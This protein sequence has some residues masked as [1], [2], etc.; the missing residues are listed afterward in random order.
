MIVPR[1]Y[2]LQGVDCVED[3]NGRALLADDMGL[4][5]TIQALLCL[6][7][8][9]DAFPAVVV[10]PAAVKY[11]WQHE[12]QQALNTRVSVL[13][14]RTPAEDGHISQQSKIYVVNYDIL[15]HW[16]AWLRKRQPMSLII[17]EA[18][19]CAN[20]Q[21]QR[22][23]STKKL[24][25]QVKHVIALTGTPFQNRPIEMWPTLNMIR[26]DLFP[27]RWTYGT[28]YCGPKF[29]FGRWEFKGSTNPKRLAKLLRQEL[30]IRRRKS[31]VEK[32][33]PEKVR[34]IITL[35]IR[36]IDEYH[37][38]SSDF[39][40]WLKERDPA[41]A[42]RAKRATAITR[43]NYL[44]QLAAKLKMRFVVEWA[45]D[46]LVNNPTEKLVLFAIHKGCIR[47]LAKR[48][49]ATSVIIDGSTTARKRQIAITQFRSDP[50]TRVFIGNIK[51]AGTGVNGLQGS[52]STMGVV[53]LPWKPGECTQAED[54]L[55]RIGQTKRT[56]INYLVAYATIE[57]LLCQIL[58]DKQTVVSSILD[59]EDDGEQEW[60]VFDLLLRKMK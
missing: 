1:P 39:L 56:W 51:A 48:V 9:P 44:R 33:L 59:H 31:E 52:C 2:Q 8:L 23:K 3:F 22:T 58:Q 36:D 20:P 29:M 50:K 11:H 15:T 28:E 57:P 25:R 27:S 60:D 49:E 7:R 24:A 21:T 43:L 13:E 30:M 47:V 45:N 35:P 32:D 38:A 18:H 14:T 42:K 34:N 55:H 41:K 46:F 19:L 12:A 54:R 37:K 53:E 4:G 5:K 6:Q 10:C 40:N 16:L 26:P 17:D